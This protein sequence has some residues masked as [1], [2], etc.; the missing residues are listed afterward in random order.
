MN[1][2]A[3]PSWL[4]QVCREALALRW[5][6][7]GPHIGFRLRLDA[8][9]LVAVDA[10][11][12]DGLVKEIALFGGSSLVDAIGVAVWWIRA[13]HADDWGVGMQNQVAGSRENQA[14]HADYILN[15]NEVQKLWLES[16]EDPLTGH[17]EEGWTT[18]QADGD[19]YA[20]PAAAVLQDKRHINWSTK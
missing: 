15:T 20:T 19:F 10:L 9:G 8:S 17:Y 6:D 7:G 14:C 5:L 3:Y 1:R 16:R 4:P 18:D 11:G 12:P 13:K 2:L